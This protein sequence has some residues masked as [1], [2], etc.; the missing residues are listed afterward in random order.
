MKYLIKQKRN[1]ENASL[2]INW[3]KSFR[4]QKIAEW[5]LFF[6]KFDFIFFYKGKDTSQNRTKEHNNNI[7]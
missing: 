4:K 1:I 5:N 3:S 2:D 7:S 6:Y